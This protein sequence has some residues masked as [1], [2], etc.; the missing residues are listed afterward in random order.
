M[1]VGSFSLMLISLDTSFGILTTKIYF[2]VLELS[3]AFLVATLNIV[4]NF[5]GA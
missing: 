3:L 1:L 4:L 2:S 5:L